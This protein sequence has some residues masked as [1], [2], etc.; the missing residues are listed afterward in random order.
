MGGLNGGMGG[1]NG[2]MF[3]MF[4]MGGSLNGGTMMHF[5]TVI[6]DVQPY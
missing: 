6:N 5:G 4:R 1:K 3:R 2:G